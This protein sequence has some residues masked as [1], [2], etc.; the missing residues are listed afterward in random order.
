MPNQFWTEN[1]K[2]THYWEDLGLDGRK[3]LEWI[4]EKLGMKDC[5]ELN[6][7]RMLRLRLG[8]WPLHFNNAFSAA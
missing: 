8:C 5:T 6:S 3:I 2:Q 7:S 4:L 1:L